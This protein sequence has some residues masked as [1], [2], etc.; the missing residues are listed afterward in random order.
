LDE[1]ALPGGIDLDQ[2]GVAS[3]AVD[4]AQARVLVVDIGGGD[5]RTRLRT[6]VFD[7]GKLP[8][9][10]IKREAQGTPVQYGEVRQDTGTAGQGGT[11]GGTGGSSYG[12]WF[13]S[14]AGEASSTVS[15]GLASFNGPIA[16]VV[17][18]NSSTAPRTP[19]TITVVPG[20]YGVYFG[21]IALN[22]VQIFAPG[23]DQEP[24]TVTVQLQTTAA[25]APGEGVLSIGEFYAV[26]RTGSRLVVPTEIV[27]TVT[28]DD[29]SVVSAVV[30]S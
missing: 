23:I 27:V 25:L 20:G 14:A 17:L 24:G 6:A 26:G 29:G 3:T 19:K 22:G 1:T 18:V 12:G 11:G 16:E 8:G 21:Q 2:D 13:G 28:F 4:P 9:I 30:K 5:L 7:F 15:A 10:V